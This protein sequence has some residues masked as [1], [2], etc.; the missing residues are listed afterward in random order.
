MTT[1]IAAAIWGVGIL[2]WLIIRQPRRRTAKKTAVVV[3]KKSTFERLALGLCIVGLVLIPVVHLSTDIFSFAD[4]S[5]HQLQGF[6]GTVAMAAFLWLFYL[7]HKQI[8]KNWSVT[9]ELRENH[10][11]V[12]HGLYKYVR[13]PMYSSF[14]LWGI[15]Q[16]LL[17]PNWIAGFCGLLSVA[18]LY[19]SRVAKEE[20]MMRQQFGEEYDAYCTRTGRIFPRI[21]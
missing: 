6:I 11:L 10:E 3:D 4:Y 16:A 17:L 15:A 1:T 13:H 9:L 14:W 19:F 5:F 12:Q 8:G 18:I 7:S 20:D 2:I 21:L